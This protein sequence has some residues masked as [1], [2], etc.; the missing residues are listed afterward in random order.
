MGNKVTEHMRGHKWSELLALRICERVAA[1]ELLKVICAEKDMPKIETVY[2]W[3][4]LYPPFFDAFHRAKELSASSL[5]EEALMMARTLKDPND[6]TSVKVQAYNVAMQQLRW[7]AA[8]RNPGV[9]GQKGLDGGG[10][11]QVTFNTSL[12]IAADGKPATDDNKNVFTIEFVP[13]AQPEEE[14]E[15]KTIEVELEAEVE[16]NVVED[17][18]GQPEPEEEPEEVNA[19]G[20]PKAIGHN[21]QKPGGRPPHTFKGV[22]GRRKGAVET[23]R[24]ATVRARTYKKLTGQDLPEGFDD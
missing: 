19:F 13:G 6:F 10:K 3:L 7:S 8:R 15:A 22:K 14:P 11:V 23:K 16:D 18:P 4:S 24:A 20:V 2:K 1:G 9:Y 5:E 12:N 21:W 17:E